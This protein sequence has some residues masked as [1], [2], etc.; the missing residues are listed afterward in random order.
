MEKQADYLERLKNRI[1]QKRIQRRTCQ[2]ENDIYK[3][4]FLDG[5]IFAI[6]QMVIDYNEW[7]S[8]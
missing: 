4:I 8:D 1:R 7:M 5:E 6:E 2:Q 3:S